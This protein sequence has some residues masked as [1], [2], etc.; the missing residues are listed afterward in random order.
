MPN[1]LLSA[2]ISSNPFKL[3]SPVSVGI[4]VLADLVALGIFTDDAIPA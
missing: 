3:E 2:V 4:R 1:P